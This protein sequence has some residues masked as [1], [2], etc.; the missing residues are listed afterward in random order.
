MV[1]QYQSAYRR[2]FAVQ[3]IQ[4]CTLAG[5]GGCKA[6]QELMAA[7][8]TAGRLAASDCRE[9]SSPRVEPHPLTNLL[10]LKASDLETTPP[11]QRVEEPHARFKV[12]S[13][14][15]QSGAL[16]QPRTLRHDSE[17][18]T[19]YTASCLCAHMIYIQ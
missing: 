15:V 19:S 4:L 10:A 14:S 9:K 12:K 8:P 18:C 7:G 2:R 13:N 11:V 17:W 1:P 6:A 16:R 5:K 3:A